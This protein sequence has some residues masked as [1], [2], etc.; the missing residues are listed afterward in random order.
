MAAEVFKTHFPSLSTLLH[1]V[2]NFSCTTSKCISAF[3]WL[4]G[5]SSYRTVAWMV[6][7]RNILFLRTRCLHYR[8]CC[9]QNGSRHSA[10]E[11]SLKEIQTAGLISTRGESGLPGPVFRDKWYF[12]GTDMSRMRFQGAGRGDV[13][14]LFQN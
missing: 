12:A 13:R 6:M 4:S 11:N 10:A 9:V 1:L 14:Q 3:W 7:K 5:E 8:T 2:Q